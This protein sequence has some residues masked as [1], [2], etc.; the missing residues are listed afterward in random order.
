[1]EKYSFGKSDKKE[2]A[3]NYASALKDDEFRKVVSEL[4]V[5]DEIQETLHEYSRS[6]GL[7]GRRLRRGRK[8]FRHSEPSGELHRFDGDSRRR[9]PDIPGDLEPSLED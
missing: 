9:R 4:D 2:L 7:A 5:S 6:P 1:M 3:N 8:G